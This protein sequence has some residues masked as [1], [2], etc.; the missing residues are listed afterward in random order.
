MHISEGVLTAPVLI[1]GALLA[2]GGVAI[3]LAKMR[4][5]DV[6]EVAVLSS[7]FFVASLIHIPVGPVSSHLVLIGITGLLL[8][9]MAFPS[10][11]V[12]L[13]LQAILFQY[14]GLTTLGVNTFN[15]A[16][17]ALVC[18]ML[19]APMVKSR[20]PRKVW[21]GG[22]LA[23]ALSIILGGILIALSLAASNE[24]FV[25]VGTLIAASNLP[26]AIAEGIL[27]GFCVSFISKVKPELLGMKR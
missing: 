4:P 7:A 21:L 25:E 12:G 16:F 13:T 11:L 9:W 18:H 10:I 5:K 8:G 2:G 14:G 20:L 22:F 24:G 19:F 1:A 17:P 3:G 6:P 27:T 26:I 23:G 15:M